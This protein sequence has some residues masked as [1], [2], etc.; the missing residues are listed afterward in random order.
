MVK[1]I[2]RG[3]DGTLTVLPA[4]QARLYEGLEVPCSSLDDVHALL[5]ILIHRPNR[6]VVRGGLANGPKAKNITRRL[7]IDPTT[8]QKPGLIEAKHLWLA[9]DMDDV[10]LPDGVDVTDFNACGLTA[11]S[12]LPSE[13][14]GVDFIVQFS[15]S[16]GIKPGIRVRLWF[17]LSREVS[18]AELEAWLKDFPVDRTVFRGPQPIYTAIPVL[19]DGCSDHLPERLGRVPGDPY[20]QVPA[21]IY[22][23]GGSRR[24]GLSVSVSG[25]VAPG[26]LEDIEA[27]L[28]V[29]KPTGPNTTSADW[30][31]WI[32]AGLGCYGAS[33]ASQEAFDL[34]AAWCSG[35]ASLEECAGAWDRFTGS[36]PEAGWRIL[37]KLA[38][39]ADPTWHAPSDDWRVAEDD[40][41]AE[42]PPVDTR[43][44][45]D[46][47]ALQGTIKDRISLENR[48]ADSQALGL[49]IRT[50]DIQIADCMEDFVERHARYIPELKDWTCWQGCS[51]W[52][53]YD[54]DSDVDTYIQNELKHYVHRYIQEIPPPDR[55]KLTSAARVRA[56]KALLRPRVT[57][58]LR[59][60]DSSPYLLQT[61][62]GAYDL[63]TG[64]RIGLIR[65]WY[66]FETRRTSVTPDPGPTPMFD[67]LTHHLCDDNDEVHRWLMHYL[68]YCLLGD[69]YHQIF[70]ILQGQ[71][72]NG[73]GTLLTIIQDILGD[74][75]ITMN[76]E[77]ILESGKDKH[78]TSL[79]KIRQRRL[80][81]FQEPK[82]RWNES[83]L[84]SLT[85]GDKIDAREM[86]G[87]AMTL[88]PT[89][90]LIISCNTMPNLQDGGEAMMRRL[91]II[92]SMRK[93]TVII[94]N[95]AKKIVT[96]EGAAI[97]HKCIQWA[98]EVC[99]D[100]DTLRCT[101]AS[102]TYQANAYFAQN[103]KVYAWL[104]AECLFGA[105]YAKSE[106]SVE[107]AIKRFNDF[108]MRGSGEVDGDC[109]DVLDTMNR[110]LFLKKLEAYGI[111]SN[112]GNG[113][114]I[115]R[116]RVH[117]MR[118]FR[119]KIAEVSSIQEAAD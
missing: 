97:L 80:A 84:K 116:D 119:F 48:K 52:G 27:A 8:K 86:H 20:V 35:Y 113:H 72:G 68:G 115:M 114:P 77:V 109:L 18:R 13:F 108:S 64:Q 55:P 56:V 50:S 34:W 53:H 69:P 39:V 24:P 74:F 83:L 102:M 79:F 51:G 95:L 14:Q 41:I 12:Y 87:K 107:E 75:A 111:K 11:V 7:T 59:E 42:E 37:C 67:D 78:P 91:R 38:K 98:K 1:M 89:A 10:P 117:V 29:I 47:F 110:K 99:E 106:V 85:G 25:D 3:D 65:Q 45:D 96:S 31:S 36:P 76:N 58:P 100:S 17:W 81:V 54:S 92:G 28:A 2:T 15:S 90:A 93:P 33:D 32:N 19:G 112:D 16:H 49:N 21:E 63:R 94:D 57:K 44:A 43:S 66:M 71:G 88:E 60:M 5:N 46:L 105:E 101:P 22:V 9:L 6:F 30:D 118:G 70:C 73:K 40:F 23:A 26:G 4:E 104:S 61:P 62:D 82:G 103:D